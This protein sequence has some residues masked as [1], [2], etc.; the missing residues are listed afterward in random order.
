MDK[1]RINDMVDRKIIE[2]FKTGVSIGAVQSDLKVRIK[3]FTKTINSDP[4]VSYDV[5]YN[6]KFEDIKVIR[7]RYGITYIKQCEKRIKDLNWILNK[8]SS[9]RRYSNSDIFKL[10]QFKEKLLKKDDSPA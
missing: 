4:N 9:F 1:N 5:L 8:K 3:N 6:S 7:Q 10:I 2:A